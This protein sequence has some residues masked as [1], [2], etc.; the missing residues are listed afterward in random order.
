MEVKMKTK[1]TKR[2]R[3][4]VA[5]YGEYR[6][7]EASR[8]AKKGWATRRKNAKRKAAGKKIAA[9]GMG[10]RGWFKIGAKGRSMG[11]GNYCT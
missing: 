8:A 4:L 3:K 11:N 6:F 7:K 1:L 9:N 10:S 2:Q 5:E